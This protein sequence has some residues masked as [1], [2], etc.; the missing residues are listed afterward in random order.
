MK[1]LFAGR[2]AIIWA[3]ILIPFAVFASEGGS[4]GEA[5]A[6]A[7]DVATV[8]LVVV[9][10][11]LVGRVGAL[12]ERLGQPPV[13]GELLMGVLVGALVFIPGLH[14]IEK[15][16]TDPFLFAFAEIGV[17]L[18]LFRV[19]LES[20]LKEMKKVGIPAFLVA[21]VGVVVPFL[22]GTFVVGPWLMPG[23][24][25]NTYLFLGATLTA[26]SVGITARVFGDL[27]FLERK[28]AKIV[29][30]AA[31]IDDILGLLILAV[32]SAI[33]SVG[34]VSA[35]AI[36]LITL[37]AVAFLIGAIIVGQLA[38]P[39]L[40][41]IFS[42]IHT[43]VGMK[44]ALA[45]GFCAAFAWGAQKAGLA[46]IVGAFAAGLVLDPVHF[47]HFAAPHV[48]EKLRKLIA[49]MN[50]HALEEEMK[51]VARHEEH[52]HVEE[53]IDGVANFFVPIFFVYTGMQ[54]NLEAFLDLPVLLVAL[55]VTAAAFIGKV[56]SMFAAG[57][58]V[59]KIIVG[60]GMI[61]RGEV[62]LIFANVGKQL[63]VVDDK[64]FAVVVIMVI[65]TTLLTPPML[66]ALIKKGG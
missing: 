3:L 20:N 48:V 66:T 60:V 58:G 6:H 31:V 2:S 26:T 1:K 53:V 34:S 15:W 35:G 43:G 8:F 45:L 22:L 25:F 46:P 36:G 63:G 30:G 55:G 10:L 64:T 11:L 65:L 24:S 54:V 44:L 59:R 27:N 39:R 32:V 38:A 61:P 21:I 12:A 28:E 17:I 40:G 42:K 18:L 51:E 7:V 23:Y 50:G 14:G 9:A 16:K 29:L 47:R 62:G 19:G 56:V 57:R 33:V 5:T 13:L 49:R 52:R 37:K 4:N 41:I